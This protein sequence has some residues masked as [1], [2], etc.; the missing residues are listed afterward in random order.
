MKSNSNIRWAFTLLIILMITIVTLGKEVRPK[1]SS[2]ASA[3]KSFEIAGMQ[4]C[5]HERDKTDAVVEFTNTEVQKPN[6]KKPKKI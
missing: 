3:D 5:A 6:V 1:A 2:T 4:A